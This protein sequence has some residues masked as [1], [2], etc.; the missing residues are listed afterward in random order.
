M[1]GVERGCLA[2][3]WPLAPHPRNKNE[4][5]VWDLAPTPPSCSGLDAEA[6][7]AAPLHA[8]S[9]DLP[10]GVA[11]LPIKTIHVNKRRSSSAT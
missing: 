2:L 6:I 5:I 10:E 11:R 8:R 9:E 4:I 7:R 3:V 1:Y